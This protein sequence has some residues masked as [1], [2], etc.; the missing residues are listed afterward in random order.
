MLRLEEFQH[1]AN[2]SHVELEGHL[3]NKR[4]IQ[5]STKTIQLKEKCKD[6]KS[7]ISSK[8][9]IYLEHFLLLEKNFLYLKTL[10]NEEEQAH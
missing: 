10:K 6:Y 8:K 2:L 9:H 1:K 5:E 3:N 7:S 4:S